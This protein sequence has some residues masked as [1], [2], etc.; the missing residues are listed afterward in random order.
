M[1]R[2]ESERSQLNRIAALT[3]H[4]QGKTNT[5][6]AREKFLASFE[7][8]VDPDGKLSPQERAKRAEQAKKAYFLVLSL[9]SAQARRRAKTLVAEAAAAE[10]EITEL[11]GDAEAEFA[12]LGDAS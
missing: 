11:G 6:A 8:Q 9:K 2:S 1:S 10:A 5:H 7:Q 12:E 3:M 4:S